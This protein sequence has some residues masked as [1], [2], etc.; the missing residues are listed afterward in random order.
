[1]V[2]FV[3]SGSRFKLF[4]PKENKK[5]TFVLAGK[6]EVIAQCGECRYSQLDHQVSRPLELLE[7]ERKES[8]TAQKAKNGPTPGIC[9]GISKSV[10]LV[11]S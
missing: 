2:D 9:S 11:D 6:L 4:L 1:M 3:A 7:L 10:R 5:L 8:L